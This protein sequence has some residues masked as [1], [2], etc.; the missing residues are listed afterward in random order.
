M[1]IE[2]LRHAKLQLTCAKFGAN[3]TAFGA[4]TGCTAVHGQIAWDSAHA[5]YTAA[6]LTHTPSASGL[7]EAT[8]WYRQTVSLGS[9]TE[10]RF[11]REQSSV[12]R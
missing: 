9:G 2:V 11:T 6:S 7:T 12:S 4:F 3:Q 8:Y 10:Y 5:L 1:Q